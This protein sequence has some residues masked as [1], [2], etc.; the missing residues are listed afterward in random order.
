M[1]REKDKVAY[2]EGMIENAPPK[3]YYKKWKVPSSPSPRKKPIDAT[4]SQILA[5]LDEVFFD[6]AL[7]DELIVH[8][9]IP[10]LLEG[11]PP[12]YPGVIL[13]GPPGTGKSEFQRAVRQVYA[14][15]GAYAA[16]APT[17]QINSQYVGAAAKTLDS[18][19]HEVNE[20]GEARHLPSFVSFD[21]GSIFAQKAEDGAFSVSKHY[22]ELIDVFKSYIGNECGRWLVLSISTNL[23]P[24]DFEQAMIRE[25]R[26]ASFLI[27]Y[28]KRR[29]VARMWKHFLKKYGVLDLNDEEADR[30]AQIADGQYGAF[31]EQFCRGYEELR[32][33][34]LLK[35]KGYSNLLEAL[36]RD[37]DVSKLEIR[38]S[39]D[40]NTFINDLTTYIKSREERDRIEEKSRVGFR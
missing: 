23:L 21:E 30:T 13:F 27:D 34:R 22:Q 1:V 6:D 39:T 7:M 37:N 17:A 15:R 19:L 14:G 12:I 40:F 31:I 28:P 2:I 26:L 11:K 35:E 33:Q 16:D 29:E 8:T 24:E 20:E 10:Q 38:A 4:R 32:R 36:K 9:S 18:V 5:P 3:F 25:G